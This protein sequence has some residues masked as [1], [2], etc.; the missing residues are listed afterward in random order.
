LGAWLAPRSCT[1]ANQARLTS[2]ATTGRG[3]VK[4]A[5]A[6][7]SLEHR[8]AHVIGLCRATAS[9]EPGHAG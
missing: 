6:A 2:A 4:S 1:Q 5:A 9:T 3:A 7:T 8:R